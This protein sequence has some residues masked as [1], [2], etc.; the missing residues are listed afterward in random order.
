M[1]M[2]VISFIAKR[3]IRHSLAL[4]GLRIVGAIGVALVLASSTPLPIWVYGIWLI[5]LLATFLF[6]DVRIN[7]VALSFFILLCLLLCLL[8]LPHHLY[9]EIPVSRDQQILVIGDSIS[10]GISNSER[11]WPLVLKDI[12]HLEM[13]NLSRP[14]ATTSSA[15]LQANGIIK[16][17]SLVI[18]EIG[19][20]DMLGN[21]SSDRFFKD[22][23]I[24]LEKIP[25]SCQL[26]M[27]EIPLLPFHNNYGQA[28]RT[29]A[30]KH[31]VLLIPKY[32]LANI[33]GSTGG[34]LDGL[35]LSQKGHDALANSVFSM[36]TITP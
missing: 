16:P 5:S 26:V 29:L 17:N 32:C 2:V 15:L 28:Q 12:S 7:K 4:A 10:A 35:H 25:S 18:I 22:L 36:L 1:G 13:T 19:G 30:R 33:I 14:G 3:W 24:L 34:T 23:D 21:I 8:E 27:F 20:N 9:P 6:P 31:K 11:N